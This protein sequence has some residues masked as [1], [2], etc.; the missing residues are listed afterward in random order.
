MVFFWGG[1]REGG[2]NFSKIPVIFGM[3]IIRNSPSPALPGPPA[4]EPG[5]SRGGAAGGGPA[6]PEPTAAQ[7]PAGDPG[8]HGKSGNLGNS[9]NSGILP[10]LFLAFPELWDILYSH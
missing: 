4:A 10:E 1:R 6:A 9:G 5:R 7:N 8:N 2:K 3:G